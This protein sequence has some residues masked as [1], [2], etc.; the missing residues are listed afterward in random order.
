MDPIEQLRA[1]KGIFF[2]K[3]NKSLLFFMGCM[4]LSLL[5]YVVTST[6]RFKDPENA[7]YAG[8]VFAGVALLNYL[9]FEFYITE[10]GITFC[11][12]KTW[13]ARKTLP[14]KEISAYSFDKTSSAKGPEIIVDIYDRNRTV[15]ASFMVGNQDTEFVEVMQKLNIP[16]LGEIRKPKQ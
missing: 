10:A 14:L 13:F 1:T 16:R 11:S 8:S 6:L 7:I 9:F 3:A 12:Y 15:F 2:F 4:I 5:V